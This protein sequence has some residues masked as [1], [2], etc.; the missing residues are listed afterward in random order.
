MPYGAGDSAAH[1]GT[2]RPESDAGH[3]RE[4]P[5]PEVEHGPHLRSGQWASHCDRTRYRRSDRRLWL[6]LIIMKS[7]VATSPELLFPFQVIWPSTSRSERS[8]K[9][10][11]TDKPDEAEGHWRRAAPARA[12]NAGTI[13]QG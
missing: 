9:S 6:S 1:H 7:G 10:H 4:H 13:A 11:I 12:S 8:E 2:G 5:D 3:E